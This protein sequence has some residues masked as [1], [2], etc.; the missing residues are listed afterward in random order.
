MNLNQMPDNCQTET[1]PAVQTSRAAVC[2]AKTLEDVGQEIRSNAL[3]GVTYF[4]VCISDCFI[5]LDAHPPSGRCEFD[6][7]RNQVPDNLLQSMSVGRY[8]S[9]FT[10]ETCFDLNSL[11]FR[12][13]AHSVNCSFK[14]GLQFGRLEIEIE[15]A[16]NDPRDIENIV[17][18]LCLSLRITLDSFKGPSFL[19]SV[20]T[21]RVQHARPTK[22]RSQRRPQLVRHGGEKLIFQAI[23]FFCFG[24]RLSL[25]SQQASTFYGNRG[26]VRRHA[27][28]R[29][30]RLFVGSRLVTLNFDGTDDSTL[31]GH[32]HRHRR[33]W[34]QIIFR[35]DDYLRMTTGGFHV[36]VGNYDCAGAHSATIRAIDSD[37]HRW[38]L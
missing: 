33:L 31:Q 13:W 17:N 12:G 2:L 24:A 25:A 4:H 15:I 20:K 27:H 7:I 37:R 18:D 1:E 21:L 8:Q 16:G 28:R 30:M 10:V 35:P 5:G 38:Q 11:G 19:P 26:Q 22:N 23:G 14:H 3:T 34:S 36:I 32:R 29:C 6:G 9:R